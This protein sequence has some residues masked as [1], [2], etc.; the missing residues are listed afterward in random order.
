M[1]LTKTASTSGKRFFAYTHATR[2]SKICGAYIS[3][4]AARMSKTGRRVYAKLVG[5]YTQPESRIYA[6]SYTQN[7]AH[8]YANQHCAYTQIAC[9]Y[10][11]TQTRT[12]VLVLFWHAARYSRARAGP[13]KL[14][15]CP[16]TISDV[17]A[18]VH[19][20]F[21]NNGPPAVS[22]TGTCSCLGRRLGREWHVFPARY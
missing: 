1:L 19:P 8:V 12:N 21:S 11:Y 9:A 3:K 18:S 22:A 5:V 6:S 10:M 2:I 17:H 15:Q 13:F 7:P 20:I 14:S 4:T 16:A